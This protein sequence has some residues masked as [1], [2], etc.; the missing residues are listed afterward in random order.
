[1]TVC[2]PW[3]KQATLT[4]KDR[5]NRS[6]GGKQFLFD[7]DKV[8]ATCGNP[9]DLLP[10]VRLWSVVTVSHQSQMSASLL[11]VSIGHW[12]FLL[13]NSDSGGLWVCR[14]WAGIGHWVL[15]VCKSNGGRLRVCIPWACMDHV[16]LLAYGPKRTLF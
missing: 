3:K 14:L 2:S 13:C 16:H 9:E 15:L 1:M 11:R 7:L 12:V 8:L 6:S 4:G 10:F 5:G